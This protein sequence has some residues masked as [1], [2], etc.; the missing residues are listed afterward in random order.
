[1]THRRRIAALLASAEKW[2]AKADRAIREAKALRREAAALE[3]EIDGQTV[4]PGLP[5]PPRPRKG[6]RKA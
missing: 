4:L 6:G 2:E 5:Q 3:R 1:M